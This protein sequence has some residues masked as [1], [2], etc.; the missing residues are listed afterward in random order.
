[1]PELAPPVPDLR[2]RVLRGMAWVGASQVATQLLRMVVA[3]VLAR[4]LSP[5]EYGLA[6]SAMIFASLVLVFSDLALGA[7]LV[8]RKELTEGDKSTAFW[9]TV[10]SG[11]LFTVV[12]VAISGPVAH[13]YGQDSVKPLLMVLSASFLLTSLGATQMSLLVREMDFKRVEGLNVIANMAG[14]AA[15]I[16]LAVKGTGAWAIIGQQVVAAALLS[17]LLWRAASWRPSLHFSRGSLHY[18]SSFSAPLV[19]HRLLFYVHQN[20]DRFLIARYVG[21]AALGAYAVAYNTMLAPASRLG[22]PLQRVLAPAFARMQDDPERMAALWGRG[23]RILAIVAV[24]GLA[25]LVCV[26][27][28]FVDVVLGQ[29]WHSAAILV[30]ILAWVGILQALQSLNLDILMARDRTSTILRYSMGFT[31]A[32]I[33]AFII[34]LHWGVVGV[35]VAYA[36]SSTLVEPVLTVLTAR[37]LRISP[38][39]F[40]RSLVPVFQITAAMC[41]VVLAARY[42]LMAA[43]AD[44]LLR[45]VVCSVLGGVVFAGL[46]LWRMRDL[47]AELKSLLGRGTPAPAPAAAP[48]PAPEAAAA[49]IP[50]AA[51]ATAVGVK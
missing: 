33:C 26:A 15:G 18:L 9:V 17:A 30:Q 19:G 5:K 42:G 48:D 38:W 24:P 7:A 40:V 16:V 50:A 2:K 20:A 6:A 32:H 49:A 12:G 51:A 28:D 41:A 47:I 22:G 8:Q 4:L 39:V 23:T 34:G 37:A 13:L 36:I 44:A 11:V 35:A 27:P 43:G 46:C 3:L 1:M 29:R 10:G 25:G 21:P 14:G 31:T 45:L